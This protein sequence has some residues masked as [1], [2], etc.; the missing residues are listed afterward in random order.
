[1]TRLGMIWLG[2]ILGCA[3]FWATVILGVVRYLNG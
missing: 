1:M 3:A 2:L